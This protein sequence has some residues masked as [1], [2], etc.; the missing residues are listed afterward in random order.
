MARWF[1]CRWILQS[2]FVNK[3][4]LIRIN[5]SKAIMSHLY[6]VKTHWLPYRQDSTIDNEITSTFKN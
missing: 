4:L 6:L 2:V 3:L 1:L 5:E